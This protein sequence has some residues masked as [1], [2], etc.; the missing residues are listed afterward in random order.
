MILIIPIGFYTK[1]YPGPA[2]TWVNNSLGGFFY[3]V[4]WML[5]VFFLFPKTKPLNI[6]IWV[7]LLTC[8]IEFLQ[9]WHPSLLES[10]R[11]NFIGRTILGNSF[12]I[13]DFPYFLMGSL[14]GYYILKGLHKLDLK[15]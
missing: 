1:V 14:V 2:H 10:I 5:L 8:A 11:G 12:N 13:G 3:V 7:F 4:F 6:A 9:L 15:N